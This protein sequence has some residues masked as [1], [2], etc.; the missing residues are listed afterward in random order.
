MVFAILATGPGYTSFFSDFNTTFWSAVLRIAEAT[1][2][3]APFLVAG[4]IAAGLMRGL[5]GPARMR[6]LLGVGHWTGPFRA[7]GLGVLLPI[8][9]LGALPVARELQRSKIPSGTIL[10]F[11][12]VAPVLNPVSII[13]G[14]SHIAL[15]TLGYFAIGTFIVSVGIGMLWNRLISSKHD[16][17]APDKELVPRN[18]MARLLVA[19]DTTAKSYIGPSCI[20]CLLAL[21]AV[22]FL[23]AFLPYGV[24]QTGLTRQNP[25]SPIIMGAVAI[26]CYVTPTDVM[27]HFG[28]IVQDGYSLGAAFALIILGAGAN[29]G[30]A[31]WLRREY[32]G[33]AVSLFVAL[34]IGSTLLI[35]LTA[36]RTIADGHA[37][38]ADHTHA[39]DSFTRLHQI[40]A[41][42]ANAS[43]VTNLVTQNMRADE[44]YGLGLLGL[45][46]VVG[47]SLSLL[48]N[49]INID[50]LFVP[51]SEPIND[52]ATNRWNPTLSSNQITCV[53]VVGILVFAGFG[54]FLFY[55][56]PD[57][58]LDDI[59]HLR[60]E[61]YSAV[62]DGDLEET[63]KWSSQWKLRI[64]KLPTSLLIRTGTV[65]ESQRESVEEVLYGLRIVE[66]ALI[67]GRVKQAQVLSDHLNDLYIRCRNEFQTAQ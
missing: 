34:L 28:H 57:D 21:L 60:V 41:N 51:P 18:T 33:R 36:D 46:I 5:I 9:S 27:M 49:R 58:I 22:G 14:L 10:S 25:F 53:G 35:G 50:R 55:P 15:S 45:V 42:Q 39:F 4:A 8:C 67:Q 11:V 43:W 7:W 3:A 6:K 30:I 44:K 52:P 61:L 63:R 16:G 62:M 24:L 23:G 13:Y 1:V 19:G 26:P 56:P 12:L 38:V 29:V 37:T 20:D 66:E 65:T 31:N 40:G 47:V 59:S 2:A 64:E 54:L 17:E 48:S 32:G